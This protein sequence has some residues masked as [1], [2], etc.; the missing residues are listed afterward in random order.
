M[1][2]TFT[3]LIAVTCTLV[4]VLDFLAGSRLYPIRGG[5]WTSPQNLPYYIPMVIT[6]A[7]VILT[8][9]GHLFKSRF[10]YAA[11]QSAVLFIDKLLVQNVRM[12]FDPEPIACLALV[13]CYAIVFSLVTAWIRRKVVP[14][15]SE[16][17]CKCGYCLIG[18]LEHRCPK[19]N[20]PF[21]GPPETMPQDTG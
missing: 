11:C 12:G 16:L 6:A 1:A 3:W 10:M 19:C 5:F 9:Q 8:P 17:C 2:R 21:R 18:L 20:T 13:V 7:A 14:S 4:M 15:Q